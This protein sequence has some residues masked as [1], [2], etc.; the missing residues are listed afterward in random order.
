MILIQLVLNGLLLGGIYALISIGLT[1]IFG[2]VRVINFAHGELLMIS[3]YISYFSFSLLGLN[4]Y[5]SLLIA[6]PLMFLLGMIFDQLIIRPLREAPSHMQIFATVG[7]SIFLLNA[8]LFLFSGDYQSVNM[9]FAKE[10]VH[11]KAISFTYSKMII[12]LTA[13]LVSVC[14]HLWLK[15]T[16]TGKQVRAIAQDRMAAKLMGSISTGSTW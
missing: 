10:I 8:A 16:D 4:P 2:V 9:P 3:M 12:F 5:L 11:V 6:V 7:T 13:V 15:F 14:L 1:L